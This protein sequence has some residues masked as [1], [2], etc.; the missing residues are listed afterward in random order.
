VW[1]S[2]FED[3]WPIKKGGLEGLLEALKAEGFEDVSFE[4]SEYFEWPHV[5]N[6]ASSTDPLFHSQSWGYISSNKSVAWPKAF[7]FLIAHIA[8]KSDKPSQIGGGLLWT[9]YPEAVLDFM[10]RR[11]HVPEWFG[12]TLPIP[13]HVQ[14]EGHLVMGPDCVIGQ[15]TRFEVGVRLGARVQIGSRCHIGA[16]TRI[17]DDS[18]IGDDTYISSHCVI[19]NQGFGLYEHPRAPH[20]RHRLHV[21]SVKIGNN[22][23]MGSFV[24]VDRAV[25]GV[26]TVSDHACLDSH[27]HIGHNCI[28]G[29]NIVL[30]GFVGLAGSTTVGDR[31]TFAGMSG[32]KG[33]VVIGN[34]VV[35][36]GQ[37]GVTAPLKDGSQVKGYPARPM[38][39]AL[40]IATIQSKLPEI[41]ERLKTLEKTI[42]EKLK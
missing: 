6:L 18:I 2:T 42:K 10:I 5:S 36:A 41:Y 39:E 12:E 8:R 24:T 14:S 27:V 1:G 20:R 30:C 40:K 13:S 28:L 15:G 37:T 9:S 32:T 31:C 22:V 11:C 19:G 3:H 26:T 23:R 21:G 16:Y 4:G 7:S 34:D 29:E 35:V 25:F 38:A 17:A 33:H